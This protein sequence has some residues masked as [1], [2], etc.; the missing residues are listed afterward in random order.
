M[1]SRRK[2]HIALTVFSALL[3]IPFLGQ[4]HL[5]DW[6]EIN[7]AEAAREMLLSGNW[8][9]ITIDYQP[10][11]EKPPLFIWLQ[12]LCMK[13]FGVGEFAARL[14][15][16]LTGIITINLLYFWGEK[17]VNNR[18]GLLWAILY[19]GS[20]V[21]LFYFK[22]G[23]IDPLFNLLIVAAIVQLIFAKRSHTR[24]LKRYVYAGLLIGL[25]VLTK[26][27]VGGLVPAL[28]FI[29]VWAA[30]RFRFFFSFRQIALLVMAALIIS[31]IWFLP[32]MVTNG[33][34]V[35]ANFF[36]YQ[37]DLLTKPVASH[38]QPWYY[39]GVVL[40]FG[41]FPASVFAL[42][43]LLGHDRNNELDRWML[44]LFWVVLVLFSL[45]TTKIVHYSSLCWF[46]LTFLAARQCTTFSHTKPVMV[47]IYGVVGT[48]LS[49]ALALIPWIGANRELL[50]PLYGPK[51]KDE[52]VM[53]I[54]EQDV[55]WNGLEWMAG[56]GLFI[57]VAVTTFLLFR[58]Q[59]T[60]KLVIIHS[61]AIAL[62]IN[63]VSISVVPKIEK[64]IQGGI[65][66]FYKELQGRDVYVQ[67]LHF[68]SYAHLFYARVQPPD[69]SDQLFRQRQKFLAESGVR[70]ITE[71]NGQE[72]SVFNLKMSNYLLTTPL[73]KPV[74][75][76]IEKRKLHKLTP[77]SDRIKPVKNAGPFAVFVSLPLPAE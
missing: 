5:F 7:F 22:T 26:G 75:L 65:I 51:I 14:P 52:Q 28:V 9:R 68:K 10:F 8:S 42:P 33:L 20:I 38:G 55:Y 23:I 44:A 41:C 61:I 53:A 62:I 31:S 63:I 74:Y 1:N 18:T 12:V 2:I 16:A 43:R 58:K 27:P 15:N 50:L 3:F 57:L 48:I 35:F 39:H 66:G 11:W 77:Y 56:F 32:E 6:D 25:A 40:L 30:G 47:L 54:L 70:E 46:P 37:V 36:Q 72:R 4:V 67:P 59:L 69:T 24:D 73:D 49:L 17:L 13:I 19:T 64:H 45:V 76:V 71:L 21:P 34:G 29:A 60:E